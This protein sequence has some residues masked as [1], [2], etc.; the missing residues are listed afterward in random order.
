MARKYLHACIAL[1]AVADMLF[2]L[3]ALPK[4]VEAS[5]SAIIDSILAASDLNTISAKRIRKGLQEKVDYD[6]SH[7]KVGL[8]AFM[9]KID[10]SNQV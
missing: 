5:Y 8:A 7:Q 2:G 1:L 10:F 9:R 4:E 6:I 3:A